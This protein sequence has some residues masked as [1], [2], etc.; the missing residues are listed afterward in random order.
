M[1]AHTNKL[2]SDRPKTI[3]CPCGVE[4]TL[5]LYV[6]AHWNEVLHYTC[7]KCSR[8]AKILSGRATF[9]KRPPRKPK[10]AAEKK[11]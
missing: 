11:K 6:Y 2:A 7:P 3:Q 1:K 8:K 9:T 10:T 5:S 4:E